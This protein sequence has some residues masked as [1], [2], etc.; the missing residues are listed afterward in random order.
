MLRPEVDLI[1]SSFRS[2]T[3]LVSVCA[4]A[5]LLAEAG[6][7]DGRRATTSWVH[8]PALRRAYPLVDVAEQQLVVHDRGVTTAAAF[9]SMFD[10]TLQLLRATLGERAAELTARI[11]LL[12]DARTDQTP[13]VDERLLAPRGASFGASVQRW[14]RSRLDQPFDLGETA[15]QFSVSSRTM[16]RNFL[17]DIGKSP[18]GFVQ[19]ERLRRAKQLLAST[20]Q[21]VQEVA[22]RVGYQDPSTFSQLFRTRVGVTPRVYRSRFT[23]TSS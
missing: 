17:R 6:V 1:R 2:G 14:L 22:R 13:Y 21:P 10:V 11:M 3:Q 4:G 7:L 20:D 5:F 9:T 15:A 12:D 18:L 23:S 8:A 19:E 16:S